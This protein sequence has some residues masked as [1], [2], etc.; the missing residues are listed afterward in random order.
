MF[1]PILIRSPLARHQTLIHRLVPKKCWNRDKNLVVESRRRSWYSR[2]DRCLPSMRLAKGVD[3][4]L[5]SFPRP[6]DHG[7]HQEL[8]SAGED[9]WRICELYFAGVSEERAERHPD[10]EHDPGKL[11][12][13]ERFFA[14]QLL[15]VGKDSSPQ[16]CLGPSS[17]SVQGHEIGKNR[18]NP[19]PNGY[20]ISTCKWRTSICIENGRVQF[21]RHKLFQH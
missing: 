16:G 4:W 14:K 20:N 11:L 7:K 10:S 6:E 2:M 5:V 1:F 9:E 13:Q 3:S 17:P 19:K 8:P 21:K 15:Q 18:F 12:Q